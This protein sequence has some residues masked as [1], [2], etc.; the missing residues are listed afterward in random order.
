MK[1]TGRVLLIIFLLL[2]ARSILFPGKS[3]TKT[4]TITNPASGTGL[5]TERLIV[6]GSYTGSGGEIRLNGEPV[7]TDSWTR[8]FS[9]EVTLIN[10]LNKLKAEYWD[11]GKEASSSEIAVTFDLEGKLYLEKEQTEKAELVRVPDY[12]LVRK[13]N[14]G[15]GFSAIAYADLMKE[16]E[17]AG[18]LITNL[19]R[20]VRE[21]NKSTGVLSVLVFLKGSKVEVERALESEEESSGLEAVGALVRA[22][23]EKSS[24]G[25]ELFMFP[26]GLSGDKLALEV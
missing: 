3:P 9:K 17:L 23:Y 16:G 22:N 12:E 19:A 2:L 13:E 5:T 1:R 26:D 24:D 11:Q 6:K 8:T 18:Y 21:K 10:G 25:E 14:I 7:K 15:G 20:D 4:I